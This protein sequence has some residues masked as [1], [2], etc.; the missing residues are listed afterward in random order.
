MHV[1]F[2]IEPHSDP[3]AGHLVPYGV[4]SSAHV[5]PHRPWRRWLQRN[6]TG[7]LTLAIFL[8]ALGALHATVQDVNFSEVRA[9]L[10]EVSFGAIVASMLLAAGSY[11]ALGGYDLIALHHMRLPMP[12]KRVALT[13]FIAYAFV[14]N[15][16]FALLTGGSVRLKL[17]GRAGLGASEIASITLICGLTFTLSVLLVSGLGLLFHPVVMSHVIHLPA[18]LAFLI[19]LG[20]CGSMAAYVR[21]VGEG[22]KSIAWKGWTLRL[23]GSR[24]TMLQL[25]I[26]IAEMMCA[27]GALYVLL[28]ADPGVGFWVFLGVYGLATAVALISH[29]PGGM[30][31]FETFMLLTL[32]GVGTERLLACLLVFRCI[33]FLVPLA[34]ALM[35]LVWHESQGRTVPR[36]G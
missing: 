20:I 18:W 34:V 32:P 17:Y 15:L 26:G 22:A 31:V 28:P 19:G 4:R 27:A 9:A 30:G 11:F 23:P 24:S 2:D 7:L 10:R 13:S 35:L 29:V 21:W 16:G 25:A 12:Y 36:S 3:A 1:P 5:L 33:Y 14:N 6:G 8:L